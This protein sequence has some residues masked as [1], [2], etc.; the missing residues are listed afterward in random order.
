MNTED[1]RNV[2]SAALMQQ[3]ADWIEQADEIIVCAANGF[4]ISEGFAILQPS[5][6]FE[7][8]FSDFIRKYDIQIPLQGLQGYIHD[9]KPFSE[10]YE[11]LLRQIHYDKPVSEA[12]KSLQ[13]I[14][15]NKAAFILTTNSED[16]FVQ[17][18]YPEKD[19]FY[20][21]GRMNYRKDHS[22]IE[23][24]EL[25]SITSPADLEMNGYTN[26]THFQNKINDLN[27]FLQAHPRAVILELG[28]SANNGWIRPLVRQI[29]E[30]SPQIHFIE[31]N[32]KAN[33]M[34]LYPAKDA[35]RII[36]IEG[37]L[38]EK[39]SQLAKEVRN[40][41]DFKLIKSSFLMK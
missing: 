36:Q 1:L 10:F 4:S 24:N 21:E 23:R 32:L 35:G 3:A 17:A 9:G 30:Y 7:N 13:E 16:R 2:D 34:S 20:L 29:L 37:P 5:Q 33:P 12:M 15:S 6:W 41:L 27:A 18:G 22:R 39:L 28:V 25:S 38:T 19:V 14:T 40:K 11:R 26:S 31:M 8:N